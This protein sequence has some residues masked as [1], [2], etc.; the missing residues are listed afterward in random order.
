MTMRMHP[1]KP[2]PKIEE[3]FKEIKKIGFRDRVLCWCGA[4]TIK[5]GPDFQQWLREHSDCE[6]KRDEDE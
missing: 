6:P 5:G 1:P 2:K 4:E 3:H